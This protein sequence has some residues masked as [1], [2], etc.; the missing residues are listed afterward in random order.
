MFR[1]QG[2]YQRQVAN[3]SA[4]SSVSGGAIICGIGAALWCF[5]ELQ[6][7]ESCKQLK[8]VL[9]VFNA[10]SLVQIATINSTHN[11]ILRILIAEVQSNNPES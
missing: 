11:L 7:R 4:A 6:L 3:C 9:M 2:T 8:P 10:E 1:A 5:K